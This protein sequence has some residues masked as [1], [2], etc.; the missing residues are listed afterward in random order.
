MILTGHEHRTAYYKKEAFSGLAS[1][2][3]EGAAFQEHD[4]PNECGF[5]LM[6]VDLRVAQERILEFKWDTDHFASHDQSSGWRPYR[7]S[8]ARQDFE[9]TDCMLA[10]LEDPGAAFSHPAKPKLLLEDLFVPQN[11]EELT[12]EN[13]KDI[14]KAGIIESRKLVSTIAD[15]RR[16]LITGCERSGKSTLAKVV[17][18][19]FYHQGFVPVLLEGDHIKTDHVGGQD[20][21]KFRPYGF[22]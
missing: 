12:V 14:V 22:A 2:Y 5:N 20:L 11:A 9:L 17:F 3:I 21:S 7:R 13:G 10:R 16:V 18:R 6:L 8:K 4:D 19:H 15:R 1:D